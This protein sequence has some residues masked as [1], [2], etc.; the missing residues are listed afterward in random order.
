MIDREDVIYVATTLDEEATEEMIKYVLDNYEGA[1]EDDPTG[2]WIEVTEQ[3]IYE[4]ISNMKAKIQKH[5]AVEELYS[6][7]DGWWAVLKDGY[8]YFGCSSIRQDTLTKLY[9]SLSQI[10]VGEPY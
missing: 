4:F 6:D 5:K 7:S 10:K 9:N 2:S 1:C 3:L 8:N